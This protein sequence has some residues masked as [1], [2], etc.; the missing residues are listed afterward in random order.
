[1]LKWIGVLS[2]VVPFG[3]VSANAFGDNPLLQDF[4]NI[5]C[6][7]LH[8]LDLHVAKCGQEE[9]DEAMIAQTQ[10]KVNVPALL[11]GAS[12]DYFEKMDYGITDANHKDQ[13]LSALSPFFPGITWE[14]AKRRMAR[15][16]DNWI[17]WTAGND[18]FWTF[19]SRATLGGFDLVKTISDYPTLP[20]VRHNRWKL[21][22][23]VN[24]PCFVEATGPRADRWG[25]WLPT[26]SSGCPADPFE[27]ASKYPG[28]Q[29]G[30]RGKMLHAATEWDA[31]G[32]PTK[33]EDRELPVG[34]FYGYA[35]GIVG[36]RLFPNPDFDD[37]AAKKWNADRYYKDLNYAYDPNLIRPYRVG[38]ACAFCHVG[39]NPSHPPKDLNSPTWETLN[40]NP[41]AQYWWVDRVFDWNWQNDKNSFIY[42]LLHTSRP[43]SVDTSLVSS[44]MIN[45]PRTMN[46]VY[47]LPARVKTAINFN[48]L[49]LLAGPQLLNAQFGN[50]AD[51]K[52]VPATSPLKAL[53]SGSTVL[54]PRVLKDGSDSVGALGALNR[55]YVNI[56][57]FSEEW[58]QDF[59]PLIGG[60]NFVPFS[61]ELAKKNSVY[62]NA[63]VNQTP[64]VALFFLAASQ[65]DRL[66]E[67]LTHT[68]EKLPADTRYKLVADGDPVLETGKHAFAKNCAQCHSSKQPDQAYKMFKRDDPTACIGAN[69]LKC[70]ND[71]WTYVKTPEYKKAIDAIVMQK[72]FLDQNYL[73]TEVRIPNTVLDDQL[74]SPVATN[75]IKGDTWDNFSSD[76]YK[77]LPSIGSFLVNFP[78]P[79]GGP[80]L[81]SV[82]IKVPAGGRGYIRP[83]SLI[84]VWSTAPYL[85]NNTVG[86][87]FW[88]GTTKA[89]LDSFYDSIDKL[90]NPEKRADG[91][92]EKIGEKA[93]GYVN[94][95]SASPLRESWMSRPRRVI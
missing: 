37:D 26:R 40:S 77:S 31:N 3:L 30:A 27:D 65:K 63:T 90:L 71:Y 94:S 43:G 88:E 36:L 70:W 79:A 67:A 2:L 25:L 46:A 14:D 23:L 29:I 9:Q 72:D 33:F 68:P 60:P 57:L 49:E 17:V 93:V 4:F 12:D 8:N 75:A 22:G 83:A 56:G 11:E 7:K 51:P 6:H 18:R 20:V 91:A 44:D 41:G 19:M 86:T 48:H 45:N 28:V 13:L 76:S 39:P 47:D 10:G 21:A 5:A 58:I 34:S 61:I 42:Q 16:R 69:Y 66:A 55:V 54:S 52:I 78:D 85:E 95:F 53:S 24:E 59:I 87:F 81:K 64:D 50:I 15:G 73:S 62:W 92:N 38:M 74:C 32:N 35:T 84:S 1:M 89:R 82:K 80:N